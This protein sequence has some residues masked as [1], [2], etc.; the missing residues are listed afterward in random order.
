MAKE[1]IVIHIDKE[2]YKVEEEMLTGADL[3]ALAAIPESYD[4]YMVSQGSEDDVL[5]TLEM[6]IHIKNGI[7]FVSTPNEITP[8]EK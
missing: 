1:E 8:G 3:R 6:E 2:K 7:H 5:V 4:L